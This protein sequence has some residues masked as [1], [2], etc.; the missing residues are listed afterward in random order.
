MNLAVRWERSLTKFDCSA[1]KKAQAKI[2]LELCLGR[3]CVGCIGSD[4][5]PVLMK[6]MSRIFCP[7]LSLEFFCVL[8]MSVTVYVSTPLTNSPILL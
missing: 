6:S 2:A 8:Y 7:S 5:P 3:L 1:L 4:D